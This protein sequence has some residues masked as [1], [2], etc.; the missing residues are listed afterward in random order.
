MVAGK[1]FFTLI[2]MLLILPVLLFLSGC[3]ATRGTQRVGDITMEYRSVGS[4]YPLIMIMGFRGTMNFW[5]SDI[6]EMLSSRYKVIIFDNRG[7]GG[8]TAG[9]LQFTIEQ[10]ADDTAGLMKALGIERAHVLGWSMG[11][12][13]AQELALRHPG[14]VNRLILYAADC[15]MSAFPPSQD[16]LEIMS[17]TSGPPEEQGKRLI[18]LLFPQRWI[19]DHVNDIKKIFSRPMGDSP[20]ENIERQGVAMD[21]WK[22]SCDRLSQIKCPTL[23]VTGTDDILTPPQNSYMMVEKIPG[24]RLVTIENG[25]HGVMYQY[26]QKFCGAIIDFLK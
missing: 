25:G 3:A 13:I 11:T 8:T 19:K 16:V 22:G 23:L 7:M 10:F 2:S 18:G 17:D 9:N 24:A 14:K 6:I 5:S 20:P 1:S 26:P 12:E 4:G 21:M 15:S